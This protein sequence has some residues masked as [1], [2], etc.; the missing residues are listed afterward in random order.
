MKGGH[1]NSTN[2]FGGTIESAANGVVFY[3]ENLEKIEI[4][5]NTFDRVKL[6]QGLGLI[7]VVNLELVSIGKN[8]IKNSFFTG[9]R[10]EGRGGAAVYVADDSIKI[11]NSTLRDNHSPIFDHRSEQFGKNPRSRNP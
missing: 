8:L 4:N 10:S 3:L 6:L 1:L 2:V 5:N 7:H 9:L 11:E